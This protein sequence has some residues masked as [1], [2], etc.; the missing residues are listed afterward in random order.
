MR[1]SLGATAPRAATRARRGGRRSSSAATRRRR[2]RRDWALR[3]DTRGGRTAGGCS[4][5]RVVGFDG[6]RGGCLL[7]DGSTGSDFLR[8]WPT[9]TVPTSRLTGTSALVSWQG[10]ATSPPA[11]SSTDHRF[12]S[13][14]R[15]RGRCGSPSS[16]GRG[17]RRRTSVDSLV[18]L[19]HGSA[20]EPLRGRLRLLQSTFQ[21]KRSRKSSKHSSQTQ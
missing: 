1:P 21:P 5:A 6:N 11:R 9:A 4:S 12:A 19:E 13:R 2:C 14:G 10:S 15:S 8:D 16:R 3:S 7:L 18:P 17:R 20:H